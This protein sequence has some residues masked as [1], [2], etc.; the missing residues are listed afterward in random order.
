MYSKKILTFNNKCDKN[1]ELDFLHELWWMSFV[2]FFHYFFYKNVQM[3]K[4]E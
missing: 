3:F 1:N 2:C 4:N